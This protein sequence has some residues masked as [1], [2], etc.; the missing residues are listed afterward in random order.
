[1]NY[2]GRRTKVPRL[3]Y[4]AL[5]A[6]LVAGTQ[7]M[8]RAQT[9]VEPPVARSEVGHATTALLDLQRGNSQ[10]AP[11]QPMLGEE[12]GLAYQ[13]YMASFKSKIPTMYGSALN[14]GSGSGQGGGMSGQAPQN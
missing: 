3:S 9:G 8:A 13:R 11:E 4:C 14:Q 5:I 2:Q 1:M 7:G 6:M 10:A 12:A